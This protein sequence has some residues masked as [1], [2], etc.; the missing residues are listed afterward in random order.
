MVAGLKIARSENQWTVLLGYLTISTML[1]AIK[2]VV[3]DNFI[4]QR[5]SAPAHCV[6]KSEIRNFLSSMG[7]TSKSSELNVTD[8]ISRFWES[9]S[10]ESMS[11]QSTRFKQVKQKLAEVWQSSHT[12]FEWKD[13]LFVFPCFCWVVQKCYFEEA[14][15]LSTSIVRLRPLSTTFL[16]KRVLKISPCMWKLYQAEGGTF[17]EIQCTYERLSL[18]DKTRSERAVT[19]RQ[20]L[21]RRGSCRLFA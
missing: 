11:C 20:R 7:V 1:V 5:D 2:H 9:Y 14:G 19:F 17:F 16:Q 13:A 3:D 8:Y 6:L 4:F 12:E 15:K 10:S 21:E 18:L